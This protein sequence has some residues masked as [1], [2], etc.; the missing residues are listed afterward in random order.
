MKNG[1]VQLDYS[2]WRDELRAVEN[3]AEAKARDTETRGARQRLGPE[4]ETEKPAG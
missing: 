2:G 4:P 1:G 3:E